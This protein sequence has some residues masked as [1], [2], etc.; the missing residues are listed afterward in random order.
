MRMYKPETPFV[1]PTCYRT[2]CF[3]VVDGGDTGEPNREVFFS[4]PEGD[5]LSNEL[6]TQTLLEIGGAITEHYV[7]RVGLEDPTVSV[8]LVGS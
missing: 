7:Q 4:I 3:L 6:I 1:T 8:D 2:Y 5:D